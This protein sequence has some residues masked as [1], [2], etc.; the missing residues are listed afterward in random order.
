MK[1]VMLLLPVLWD[2]VL[3]TKMFHMSKIMEQHTTLMDYC[4]QFGRVECESENDCYA[5]LI[6]LKGVNSIVYKNTFQIFIYFFIDI[7]TPLR[8][9][10]VA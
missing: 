9:I 10:K 6:F 4:Q 8:K 2:V 3:M 5:T 7:L 1:F